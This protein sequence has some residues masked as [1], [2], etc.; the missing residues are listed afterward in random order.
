VDGHHFEGGLGLE[1][2]A[3]GGLVIGLDVRLGGRSLENS[4]VVIAS[5]DQSPPIIDDGRF[6]YGV[7]EGEYR[8]ARLTAG[9]R[10]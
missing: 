6:V 10:F 7:A 2:R 3:Q 5:P 8:A 9:V 1:Y 4:D